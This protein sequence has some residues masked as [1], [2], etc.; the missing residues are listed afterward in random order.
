MLVNEPGAEEFRR[1]LKPL[2][3]LLEEMSAACGLPDQATQAVLSLMAMHDVDT[4]PLFRELPEDKLDTLLKG[5][6]S[7]SMGHKAMARMAWREARKRE[8]PP[9]PDPPPRVASPSP[10]DSLW[11]IGHRKSKVSA[12]AH[13]WAQGMA[14]CGQCDASVTVA[15]ESLPVHAEVLRR[16]SPVLRAE[17]RADVPTRFGLGAYSIELPPD[18]VTTRAAAEAFLSFL[19]TEEIDIEATEGF[20]LD[21]LP[22]IFNLIDYYQVDMGGGRVAGP[23][24]TLIHETSRKTSWADVFRVFA[25]VRCQR[26]QGLLCHITR[27]DH[28]SWGQDTLLSLS[29]AIAFD[30]D[31]LRDKCLECAC[32]HAQQSGGRTP[33]LRDPSLKG[34]QR[35]VSAR[36]VERILQEAGAAAFARS[37]WQL[38]L[39]TL[40]CQTA[41]EW[42]QAVGA[43]IRQHM[44]PLDQVF[45][46]PSE[47]SPRA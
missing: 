23:L 33:E 16:R 42:R 4:L 36:N 2:E 14:V 15:G 24:A 44:V 28:P 41:P 40:E 27:W 25:R 12:R 3:T 22:E 9:E 35:E 39:R 8:R 21:W 13:W 26:L 18:V 45:S 38:S 6:T 29:L 11:Y 46:Q 5:D 37:M 31:L 30:V 43:A 19:Y 47:G 34:L 10:T 17:M 32:L 20:T 1:G 7:L